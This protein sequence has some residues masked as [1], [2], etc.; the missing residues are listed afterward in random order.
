MSRIFKMEEAEKVEDPGVRT[1]YWL[2]SGGLGASK[3]RVLVYEF[4][5]GVTFD[6][7]HYHNDRESIYVILEGEARV[8]LN[9]EDYTLGPG[10]VAYLSPKDVHG[11]VG[12]GSQGLKML[13]AWAPAERDT[14]YMPY[15]KEE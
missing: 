11:V 10:E 13:E 14:H 3:L 4:E 9:G 1:M 15:E 12:T 5:A 7:V 6:Q 8:H 2:A